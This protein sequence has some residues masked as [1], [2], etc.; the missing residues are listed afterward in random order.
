M[1]DQICRPKSVVIPTGAKRSG[2]TCGVGEVDISGRDFLK[3]QSEGMME[4]AD[5]AAASPRQ[6]SGRAISAAILAGVA[7]ASWGFHLYLWRRFMETQPRTPRPSEGL[8]FGMNNHGWV[9]YLSAAQS[10]QLDL[11]VYIAI[12]TFVLAAIISGSPLKKPW[13]KYAEPASLYSLI[14]F[15]VSALLWT[16][17]LRHWSLRWASWI[18]SK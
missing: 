5:S 3:R 13:Q 1:E 15:G 18:V 17:A 11:L 4:I 2:G 10:S 9:Y 12:A 7:A 6:K 8:V 14:C 16:V